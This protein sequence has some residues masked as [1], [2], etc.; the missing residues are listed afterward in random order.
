MRADLAI[1]PE[2]EVDVDADAEADA[3]ATRLDAEADATKLDAEADATRVAAVWRATGPAV[4]RVGVSFVDPRRKASLIRVPQAPLTE[5]VSSVGGSKA[6]R[7][8]NEALDLSVTLV[9]RQTRLAIKCC[10]AVASS[11]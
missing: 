2:L 5:R 3:D 1:D 6:L 9:Q 4:A 10:G 11:E 8:Q 7:H